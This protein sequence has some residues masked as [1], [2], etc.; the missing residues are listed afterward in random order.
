MGNENM[1]NENMEN[2]NIENENIENE[3]KENEN[4]ENGGIEN[5]STENDINLRLLF[6][7]NERNKGIRLLWIG[8]ALFL[9]GFLAAGGGFLF[10]LREES[11]PVALYQ[12]VEEDQYVYTQVSYLTEP[13]AYYNDME[14]MEFYLA[15][16][17]QW[18]P[19]V[20]CLHKD[21]REVFQPYI[22][23]FHNGGYGEELSEYT[24]IGYT[25]YFDEDVKGFAV[26]VMAY[27]YGDELTVEAFEDFFDS[28]YVQIGGSSS[29]FGFFNAAAVLIA[30]G[31][32]ALGLGGLYYS[33][34]RRYLREISHPESVA[35]PVIERD[36]SRFLAPLCAL[37]GALA[38]GMLWIIVGAIGFYACWTGMLISL[39][40]W[41]GYGIMKNNQ[42]AKGVILSAVCSLLVPL[43]AT[44]IQWALIYYA[45]R[46]GGIY[47]YVPFSRVLRELPMYLKASEVP[48][49]LMADLFLGYIFIL[50][51]IIGIAAYCWENSPQRVE[52][53]K[54]KEKNYHIAE[55][56]K[57]MN[58]EDT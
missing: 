44:Y 52:A 19:S 21:D 36:L 16:D 23:R 20:I 5:D 40:S 18:H 39:L 3:N 10:G 11:E 28:Y 46:N 45:D 57:Y 51:G 58:K 50:C 26:E 15:F 34:W 48:G 37:A 6:Q 55:K 47:G 42:E 2:E 17:A 29:A 53:R 7:V 22:D 32:L 49:A 31:V 8:V 33:A 27:L 56:A 30:A 9:A 12:A 25:R 24:A 38:G 54:K 13:F 35:A 4:K 41:V 14:D 1:E 43:P